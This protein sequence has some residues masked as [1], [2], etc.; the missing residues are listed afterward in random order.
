MSAG[1]TQ[2][3]RI[4]HRAQEFVQVLQKNSP[5]WK[6]LVEKPAPLPVLNRSLWTGAVPSV[7]F[8][9]LLFLS[10]A[11]A[12]LGLLA[13]SAATIIGAMII[14]PLMGPIIAIAY[15]VSM[16]NRLLLRRASFTL[17]TDIML[18]VAI[19]WT[20]LNPAI[21]GA[22]VGGRSAKQVEGIIGAAEFGF[23]EV[24]IN[25]IETFL[26]ERFQ[27]V[28]VDRS[29]AIASLSN[30]SSQVFSVPSNLSYSPL[31]IP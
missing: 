15:S 31:M 24:E 29:C 14:A 30:N 16:G 25:E 27:Q 23:G 6:W 8:Y 10:G 11:I 20:L 22:L 12:T 21:M 4:P 7:N 3:T 17:F 5:D 1:S 18:T 2:S 13:N 28:S 9:S 26:N 19:A